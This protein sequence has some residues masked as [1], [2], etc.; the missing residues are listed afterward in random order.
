MIGSAG[1]ATGDQTLDLQLDALRNAGCGKLVAE[2]SGGAKAD[3]L[4][5]AVVLS[6]CRPDDT[7]VVWRLD[8]LGRSLK[9]RIE[10]ITALAERGIGFTSTTAPTDPTTSGG[11]LVFHVFVALAEFERDV[12]RERTQARM[13]TARASC[14]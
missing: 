1:V 8:R 10:T 14:P 12:I 3:R 13:A 5:L 9:H 11:E 4:V 6:D 2:T 7:L